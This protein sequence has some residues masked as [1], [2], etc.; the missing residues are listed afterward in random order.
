MEE[1]HAVA[2]DNETKTDEA[3]FDEVEK[4]NRGK[5]KFFNLKDTAI[6]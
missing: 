1:L 3:G 2:N 6:L 4:G 5:S